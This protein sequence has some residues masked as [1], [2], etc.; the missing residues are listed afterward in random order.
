MNKRSKSVASIFATRPAETELSADNSRVTRVAAG[1]VRS[2]KESFSQ[3]ERENETLRQS[4][5]D[6]LRI[7]EVDPADIDASPFA[8][9]FDDADDPSSFER[10]K[11]SIAENGQEVPV[12]LRVHPL[13]EARFQVAFGHRRV[14]AARA[15]ERPVRAIVRSLD[16][17]ALAL[18]Q[19]IENSARQD[20]TFIERAVF[21]ARLEARGQS[22]HV[23]QQAL[24][25]D[26]AEA[27]KLIAIANAIPADVL[28]YIGRAPK[29]GRGRWQ[30]LSETLKGQGALGRVHRVITDTDRTEPSS[31]LRFVAIL[32]AAAKTV[33]AGAAERSVL[34]VSGRR[35]ASL[36]SGGQDARLVIDRELGPA[37]AEFLAERLPALYEDYA[38]ASG[39]QP[40]SDA[41]S[42]RSTQQD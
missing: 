13:D 39:V 12:L 23:V 9:R 4:L 41:S 5:Q 2:M 18:A 1:S 11:T 30:A 34:A 29:V 37:F 19:G 27:S 14:R 21:A 42:G 17:E 28:R 36:F 8:D 40:S 20:L 6:G 3:V 22:R 16:D 24:S 35:I 10:L 31:D 7:V 15:L 26:K 33:K 32:N 38:A 25:V